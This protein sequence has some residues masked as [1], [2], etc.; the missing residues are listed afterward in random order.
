MDN[1]LSEA[2]DLTAGAARFKAHWMPATIDGSAKRDR[3]ETINAA[4]LSLR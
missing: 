1:P 3:P 4:F 2:T